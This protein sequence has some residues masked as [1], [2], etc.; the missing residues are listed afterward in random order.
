MIV[1]AND[2][3]IIYLVKFRVSKS[4]W[5]PLARTVKERSYF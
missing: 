5:C 3:Q 4:V 2:L 1:S